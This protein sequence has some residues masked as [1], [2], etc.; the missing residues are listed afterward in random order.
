MRSL[1]PQTIINLE[2]TL[3]EVESKKRKRYGFHLFLSYYFFQYNNIKTKEEKLEFLGR[4]L[5][6]VDEEQSVDSIDTPI[7]GRIFRNITCIDIFK[8]ACSI[9]SST[10]FTEQKDAWD[11]RAKKLN[12]R[13]IPG[14]YAALPLCLYDSNIHE[15]TRSIQQSLYLE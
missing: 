4:Q 14:E 12:K 1:T 3:K 2:L 5:P 8:T 11:Q 10:Y 6:V 15:L 9:W 7:F 13:R